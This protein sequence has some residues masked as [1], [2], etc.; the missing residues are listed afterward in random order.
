MNK[1]KLYI[2]EHKESIIILITILQVISLVFI[3]MI[4]FFDLFEN[5]FTS[6]TLLCHISFSLLSRKIF[7]GFILIEFKLSYP[8]IPEYGMVSDMHYN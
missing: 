5:P 4:V 8:A 1:F 6:D 2:E 7:F 3:I